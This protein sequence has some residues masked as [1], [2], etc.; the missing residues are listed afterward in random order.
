MRLV[1]ISVCFLMAATFPL[2]RSVGEEAPV[3]PP[4][5]IPQG[6]TVNCDSF[7]P[8]SL[9]APDIST[10]D[11]LSVHIAKDGAVSKAVLLHR[12]SNEAFDQA[13]LACSKVAYISP[14][15][16]KGVPIDVDWQIAIQWTA[17]HSF[18]LPVYLA[19]GS[20]SSFYPELS[21]RLDEEGFVTAEFVIDVDG[22]V[23]DVVL[24]SSTGF[25]RLDQASIDCLSSWR[26][27]VAF[28]YGK[29]VAL[30]RGMNVGWKLH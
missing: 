30:E 16:A 8:L 24:N 23:R 28:H 4:S 26:Y 20:C 2:G 18:V 21:R 5:N 1:R 29:P 17:D 25:P 6:R 22:S 12:S 13:A 11:I 14:A 3:A 10:S 15:K 7:Y 27:P 19:G 9:R